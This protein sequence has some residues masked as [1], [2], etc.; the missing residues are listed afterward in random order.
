M[1][2]AVPNGEPTADLSLLGLA[3]VLL[4]HRRMIIILA[5]GCALV[6]GIVGC[7]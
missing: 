1:N 5:L 7:C 6:T 4:Q 2:M 3:R